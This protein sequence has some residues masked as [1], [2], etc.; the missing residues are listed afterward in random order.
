RQLFEAWQTNGGPW[1]WTSLSAV[2]GST[3]ISLS[4]SPSASV[5]GDVVT[6]HVRTSAGNLSSFRLSG[7]AWDFLNHGG[8]ITE[9]PTSI[10]VGAVVRGKSAGLW[11]FDGIEWTS[12]G[13]VF[14]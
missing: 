8:I 3:R 6:V 7:G 1:R 13:G 5:Q 4:G 9:S 14:D 10:P 2:T 11:R 12:L